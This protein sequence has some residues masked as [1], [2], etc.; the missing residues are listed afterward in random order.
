MEETSGVD[1]GW[2]FD[3]WLRRGETPR[4][5]GG[6]RYDAAARQVIVDLAQMQPGDPFR[7]PLEIALEGGA[8]EPRIERVELRER[9]H[10]FTF[11]A[12]REPSAVVLDPRLSA[13]MAATFVKR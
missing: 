10:Q 3:Q 11:A 13:L 12:D 7:L 2:F 1:L 6:W 9:R 4:L 5:D 8:A